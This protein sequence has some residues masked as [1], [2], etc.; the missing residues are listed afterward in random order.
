MGT[1]CVP[2]VALVSQRSCLF[3]KGSHFCLLQTLN[4]EGATLAVTPE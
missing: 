4:L 1:C 3:W 2:A